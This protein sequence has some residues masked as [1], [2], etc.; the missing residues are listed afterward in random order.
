MKLKQTLSL[1][2]FGLCF[3]FVSAQS[4][5]LPSQTIGTLASI[6][7]MYDGASG[8]EE[9]W[10]G[11]Y[12]VGASD[13]GHITFQY[14]N[15]S[16]TGELVFEGR[17][18][19]GYFNFRLFDG[20]GNEKIFTSEPLLIKPGMTP[21]F[22]FQNDGVFTSDFLVNELD[23]FAVGIRNAPGQKIVAAGA[24]KTGEIGAIGGQELVKII[25]ARFNPDGQLD[26]SFG[27][28]GKLSTTL[29]GVE[30]EQVNELVVQSDGK[31]IV[32]GSVRTDGGPCYS[33]S[34]FFLLRYLVN[35][36]I[37]ADFGVN[38]VVITN[39]TRPSEPAGL[40]IDFM[41][42]MEL[43][44]DG[45]ILAG[46]YGV[47]C[48]NGWGLPTRCNLARYLTNGQPDPQFG[49]DGK[50]T[51]FTS[52]L[53]YP[54]SYQERVDAILPP[55][56]MENGSIFV[57][58]TSG[59]GNMVANRQFIYKF[60]LFGSPDIE[61]GQDGVVVETRPGLNNDQYSSSIAIGPDNNLYIMGCTAGNGNIWLMKKDPGT[62]ASISDF[63]DNGVVVHNLPIGCRPAGMD[64]F[65]GKI[66]VGH[67]T[68]NNWFSVSKFNFDGNQ[69]ASFGT[70]IYENAEIGDPQYNNAYAFVIQ[71][72]GRY[73]LAGSSKY[74]YGTTQHDF[75]VMRFIDNPVQYEQNTQ[76]ILLN[77]GW[78]GISSYL[79]PAYNDVEAII[80]QIDQNFIILS[81]LNG[82]YYPAN[83]ANDIQT[84]NSE[85]GYW[86][87]VNEAAE[88]V[89]SGFLPSQNTYL[90]QT[91]W[92]LISVLSDEPVDINSVFGEN[93]PL[94]EF[95]KEALG[96]GV[97]WPG[98]DIQSIQQFMPGKA[99]LV[100]MYE[101]CEITF[102]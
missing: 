25:V 81:D 30:L 23:D 76:A 9:S 72:D 94:L 63:G 90:L 41:T 36:E 3:M 6:K 37:D 101:P 82:S 66:C 64:F 16:V 4:I 54:E 20:P 69:D 28:N 50:L 53:N 31:I 85:S 86:I 83:S 5:I 60:D 26:P 34:S 48:G 95:A 18:E 10:I 65:N 62:G 68:N 38:G 2:I 102:D 61:F 89:I 39:F 8:A 71:P 29:P 15:A 88:L 55:S 80:A 44:P 98:M 35:G 43:Q 32:G 22:T 51:F 7:I 49:T 46:G 73:L 59:D 42:S 14:I 77:P 27:Q 74:H 45:K 100:K 96:V 58:V 19:T 13:G 40:S 33:V 24:A 21:D 79:N 52:E 17:E 47:I 1:L 78:N 12:P 56:E 75:V 70:P 67:F 99:Y 84:W 93:L 11:L 97:F 92:N 87:K 91:G 57:S